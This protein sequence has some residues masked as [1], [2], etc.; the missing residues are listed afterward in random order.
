M[1]EDLNTKSHK[2]KIIQYS[3]GIIS[4]LYLLVLLYYGYDELR[5]VPFSSVIKGLVPSI[6]LYLV[7][8]IL[9]IMAWSIIFYGRIKIDAKD[10]YIY[11]V[12][13]LMRRLPG[14]FWH[15]AGR[16]TLYNRIDNISLKETTLSSF[17]EWLILLSTGFVAYFALQKNILSLVFLII[18]FFFAIKWFEK[19]TLQNKTKYATAILLVL[20][21]LGSWFIG[22][23]ILAINGNV[24]TGI[25]VPV[26]NYLES[27]F[28]SSSISM[29]IIFLPAGFGIREVTL[30]L[31]LKPLIGIAYSVILA[32]LIRIIFILSELIWGFMGLLIF[33]NQIGKK[34]KSLQSVPV[35]DLGPTD[36]I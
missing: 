30:S 15:W 19:R 6:F 5:N 23:V 13:I 31:L 16:S 26:I 8:L 34:P 27:W 35:D 9:Q 33:K 11:S 2:F 7:S 1:W 22:G 32:V 25:D 18:A 12:V 29:I 14:G 4:V 10:I 17:I 20:I 21:Y 28:L 3:F 36:I 24:L